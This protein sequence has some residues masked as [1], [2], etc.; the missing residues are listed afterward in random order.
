LG[1]AVL[2]QIDSG[3]I[4]GVRI[5][6]VD[7]RARVEEAFAIHINADLFCRTLQDKRRNALVK[8]TNGHLGMHAITLTGHTQIRKFEGDSEM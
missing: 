5:K 4:W 3:N 7:N 2:G 6:P 8:V 1:N